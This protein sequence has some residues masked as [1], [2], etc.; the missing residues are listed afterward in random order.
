MRRVLLVIGN[1][2]AERTFF[3]LRK[4]SVLYERSFWEDVDHWGRVNAE[5]V[6]CATAPGDM[7]ALIFPVSEP[8]IAEQDTRRLTIA[9]TAALLQRA[10]K[11][12]RISTTHFGERDLEIIQDLL[13]TA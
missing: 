1:Q 13:H 4:D 12:K 3:L 11:L 6:A 10:M 2:N 5:G 8:P 9:D 7:L